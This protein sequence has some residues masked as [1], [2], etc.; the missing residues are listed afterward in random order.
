MSQQS[1]ASPAGSF[2][3]TSAST[4]QDDLLDAQVWPREAREVLRRRLSS[5][6]PLPHLCGCALTTLPTPCADGIGFTKADSLGF[7]QADGFARGRSALAADKPAGGAVACPRGGGQRWGVDRADP[8]GRD[9]AAQPPLPSDARPGDVSRRAAP[10]RA[11]PPAPSRAG[12]W[13]TARRVPQVVALR[14]DV[15][16]DRWGIGLHVSPFRPHLVQHA[17]LVAFGANATLAP[18][19]CVAARHAAARCRAAPRRAAPRRARA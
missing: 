11:P 16:A 9:A 19:R 14:E 12:A 13:P 6:G 1:P 8:N 4:V 17:S 2:S 15:G 10:R 18:V 5:A 7:A 3:Q